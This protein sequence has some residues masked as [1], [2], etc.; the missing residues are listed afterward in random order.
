MNKWKKVTLTFL[1]GLTLILPISSSIAKPLY[2]SSA[3]YPYYVGSSSAK[4]SSYATWV[5][6]GQ[7]RMKCSHSSWIS[8][9][10]T[11]NVIGFTWVACTVKCRAPDGTETIYDGPRMWNPGYI[12]DSSYTTWD[13]LYSNCA[14]GYTTIWVSESWHDFNDTASPVWRPSTDYYYSY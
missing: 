10:V 7:H 5:V 2:A 12:T 9:A 6:E 11:I 8:P 1:L 13:Y 4:A 14:D 3:T